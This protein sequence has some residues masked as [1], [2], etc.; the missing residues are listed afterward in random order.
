VVGACGAMIS[1]YLIFRFVR[2][3]LVKEI[4][5]TEREILGHEIQFKI[6]PNGLAAKIIPIFAGIIIASPLPDEIGIALL[7]VAKIKT[8]TFLQYSFI[9]NLV[10]IFTITS[11]AV[12]SI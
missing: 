2:D 3:R 7:S 6:N 11:V 4:R 5:R 8:R 10:G 9:L 1:D 12:A